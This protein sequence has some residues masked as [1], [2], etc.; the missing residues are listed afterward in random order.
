MRF[1]NSAMLHTMHSELIQIFGGS[2]G[3]RDACLLESALARPQQHA[4][5]SSDATPGQLAAVLCWGLVKNHAFVDGNKRI[6]LAALVTFLRLNGYR[7]TCTEA[8]ETTM[9]LRAAASEITEEAFTAWVERSVA[10]L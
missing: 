1:L 2:Y 10:A 7:L 8:E 3:L 4:N 6:A 5:Y 9:M